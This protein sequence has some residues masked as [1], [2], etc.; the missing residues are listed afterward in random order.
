MKIKLIT[1]NITVDAADL[2]NPGFILK[3]RIIAI[4]VQFIS[5]RLTTENN[6]LVRLN[7]GKD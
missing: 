7:G 1:L 2:Q 3:R 6:Y 5:P 4:S